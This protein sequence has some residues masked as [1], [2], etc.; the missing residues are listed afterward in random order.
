M[1]GQL[2]FGR[3]EGRVRQA[4]DELAATKKLVWYIPDLLQL[5]TSGTHQGQSASILD[6]VLPAIASGRLVVWTEAG[7]AATARLLQIRPV[8][9]RMLEVVRLEPQSEHETLALAR[10]LVQ[11]LSEGVRAAIDPA[12]A[13]AAVSSARQYLSASSFP[14]SALQLIKLTVR[15]A[16]RAAMEECRR[17]LAHRADRC[18][19]AGRFRSAHSPR[20]AAGAPASLAR[21]TFIV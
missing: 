14:G 9:R 8:L 1:A 2:W 20:A 10:A 13:D 3:L 16:D 6:Q 5:A 18:G 19:V 17:Q 7:T 15:R 11:R 4:V 21:Q 12:C